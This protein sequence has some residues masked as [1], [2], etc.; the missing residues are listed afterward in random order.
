M[1]AAGSGF[2]I[3]AAVQLVLL[4][5]GGSGL[6]GGN[7]STFRYGWVWVSGWCR[8]VLRPYLRRLKRAGKQL[9]EPCTRGGQIA[10]STS[11]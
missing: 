2:L 4:A 11:G 7:A 8:S 10:L 9:T 3:A 6:L 5:G 1:L